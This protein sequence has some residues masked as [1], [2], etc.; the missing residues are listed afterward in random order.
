MAFKQ[1][2]CVTVSC[3]GCKAPYGDPDDGGSWHF[4]SLPELVADTERY[5]ED[6]GDDVDVMGWDVAQ[7]GAARCPSCRQKAHCAAN[8]HTPLPPLVEPRAHRLNRPAR[9]YSFCEVCAQE[10]APVEG[11]ESA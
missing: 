3:D 5:R 9:T 1:T 10:I 11:G 4:G 8:G 2:T 6:Y 7:D